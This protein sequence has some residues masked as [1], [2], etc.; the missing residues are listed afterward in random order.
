MN[1]SKTYLYASD[2]KI[3]WK[4]RY[5][6]GG[7]ASIISSTVNAQMVH[8]SNDYPLGR[9]NTLTL[10]PMGSK[11]T[12]IT[13][14]IVGRTP[15]VPTKDKTAAYQ[16]WQIANKQQTQSQHPRDTACLDIKKKLSE[17]TKKGHAIILMADFNESV[18][19]ENGLVEQI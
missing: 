7:T 5:K 18:D 14:Y 16:Q 6:T 13:A 17:E 3:P 1:D 2:A 10:G 9:W 12:I 8:K 4:E 15:I 19:K 11:I